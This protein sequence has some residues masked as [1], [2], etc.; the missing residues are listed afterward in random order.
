M[1][2]VP[3][4]IFRFYYYSSAG[5]GVSW[6]TLMGKEMDIIHM[7]RCHAR[8]GIASPSSCRVRIHIVIVE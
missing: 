4:D 2:V 6:I 1:I 3:M 8:Y 7:L 5:F